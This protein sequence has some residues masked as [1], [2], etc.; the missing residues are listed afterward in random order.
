MGTF[1][2]ANWVFAAGHVEVVGTFIWAA[3][4]LAS[5][6]LAY[7]FLRVLRLPP[8]ASAAGAIVWTFS[9]FMSNWSTGDPLLGAAIWLPLALGGLEVARRGRPRK[10]I[11][12]GGL[13]LGLSAL[14]GHA[15]ISDY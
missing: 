1:Y 13:G 2:P 15:Q 6:L 7:W 3:R 14:A 8:L 11:L 4:L 5:L 12:L 9:G 10:G